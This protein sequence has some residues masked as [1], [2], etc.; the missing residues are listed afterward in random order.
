MVW[1][2]SALI[3]KNIAMA[4]VTIKTLLEPY[5]FLLSGQYVKV[6]VVLVPRCRKTLFL[7]TFT[8]FL[9]DTSLAAISTYQCLQLEHKKHKDSHCSVQKCA[10]AALI[11]EKL[12]HSVWKICVRERQNILVYETFNTWIKMLLLCCYVRTYISRLRVGSGF[13]FYK[14]LSDTY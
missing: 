1:S 6:V 2:K 7:R 9:R 10:F 3:A 5:L 12:Y 11:F 14:Y 8:F 4:H 13:Y